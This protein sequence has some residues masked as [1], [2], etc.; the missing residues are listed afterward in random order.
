MGLFDFFR[1]ASGTP[2]YPDPYTWTH[3]TTR[4]QDRAAKSFAVL[5]RRQVP[6]YWGPFA[7]EDE[8]ETTLQSAADVARRLLVIWTVTLHAEGVPE[9]QT[10][11]ILEQFELHDA[12]SPEEKVFIANDNPA[13]EDRRRYAWRREAIWVLLWALQHEMLLDWP[14]NRCAVPRL[15]KVMTNFENDAGF[16]QTARLRDKSEILN[17]QDLIRRVDWAIR[18]ALLHQTGMIPANLDWTQNED[19][20]PVTDSDAALVVSERHYT[21][22]WLV[23]CYHPSGSGTWDDVDTPT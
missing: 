11:R 10:N 17:A 7:T 5:K 6:V 22:N 15:A 19:W 2:T 12:V 23:Q 20:L 3:L 9:Q 13:I 8:E 4:Q 18:D 1:K 14:A 21:L 16:I